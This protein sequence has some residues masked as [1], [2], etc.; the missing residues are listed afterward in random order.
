MLLFSSADLFNFFSRKNL[1]GTLFECQTVW[2]QIRTD[3][4]VGPDLGPNC[5]QRLSADDKLPPARKGL[6]KYLEQY[7]L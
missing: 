7:L 5:L 6:N 1:S 4:I 3:V 2:I